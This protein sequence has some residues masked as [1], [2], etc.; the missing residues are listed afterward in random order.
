MRRRFTWLCVALLVCALALVAAACG[1]DD[2]SAG[3]AD[4]SG[5]TAGGDER[6]TIATDAGKAA[7]TAAGDQVEAPQVTIGFVNIVGAVESAQ[8][9]ERT[10]KEATDVLGW[11][12]NSCD[13]QGDPTK[14]A[15]CSDSLLDQNVDVLVVLGYRAHAEPDHPLHLLDQ[16]ARH[17]RHS[18]V[19]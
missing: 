16:L 8:R 6:A 2:D 15:R 9:A 7:A 1:D 4:T 10:F 5:Q 3:S 18:R 11:K 17:P 13:A 14:M 12:V 19:T